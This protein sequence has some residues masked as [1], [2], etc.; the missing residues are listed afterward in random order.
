MKLTQTECTKIYNIAESIAQRSGK[1]LATYYYPDKYIGGE[2]Y[3][4]DIKV[5]ITK[6]FL[7]FPSSASAEGLLRW[8]IK[9]NNKEY[10]KTDVYCICKINDEVEI[11]LTLNNLQTP[12][13]YLQNKHNHE[14]KIN[15]S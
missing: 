3:F 8:I 13:E 12:E 11:N 15:I 9:I 10:A 1:L 2:M 14:P 5:E 7:D 6:M 4:N